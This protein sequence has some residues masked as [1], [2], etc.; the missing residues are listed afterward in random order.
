MRNRCAPFTDKQI[1]LVDDL[2]RPGGDRDRER[3]AVRRGAGAHARAYRGAGAA[4]RD[5]RGAAGHLKFA[6]RA[7]S[8]CSRPCWRTPREF[9]SAN[10][11]NL[12]LRR[13]R[14]VSR[15]CHAQCAAR[16]CRS[17]HARRRICPRP[18]HGAWPPCPNQAGGSHLRPEGGTGLHC[19]RP[20]FRARCRTRR[21]P[22]ATRRADA[23]GKRADWRDRHLPPGGAP[24]LRQADRAG[25]ELRRSGRHRHREHAPAQRATPAHR[26]SPDRC[27]SRPPPP[28]CS[29]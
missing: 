22:D 10:F 12:F 19:A 20:I 26:G 6:R 5:L 7:A 18:R 11:G 13:G 1:E 29:R 8:R 23:Q 9:A 24:V 16:L 21:H 14:G 27:S 4:D 2:R 3:A 17:P 15:R 28:T 25:Q